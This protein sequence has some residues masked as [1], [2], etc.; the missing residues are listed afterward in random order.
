MKSKKKLLQDSQLYV[1]LDKGVYAGR[2]I[3]NLARQLKSSGADIIQLRAKL[4]LKA[5]ILTDAFLLRKALAGSKT[6]FIVNNYLDVAK[7]VDSDGLHIGQQDIPI[8]LARRILG[9]D[10][11]I[12][13]SCETLGQALKAQ[14][15][16]ADYIGIGPIFRS[17][18][19]PETKVTGLSLIK[20]V[21]ERIKI[22]FFA[23]GN[24]N[25]S[26]IENVISSG[27]KRV[28]VC[29]A[30]LEAKNIPYAVRSFKIKLKTE[31]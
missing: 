13:V 26:N 29:R 17:P 1:I 31:S 20:R 22:P 12:G 8:G 16:G 7:I 21:K 4:S 24:I 25:L 10:K 28:A 23:I 11:I 6:L 9:K 3:L 15:L 19:K 18:L 5:D 27:A 2:S 14:A 30:I